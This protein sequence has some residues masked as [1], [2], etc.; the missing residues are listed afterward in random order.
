MEMI[1][2]GLLLAVPAGKGQVRH[3]AEQLLR[4]QRTF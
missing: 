1:P 4:T 2:W 3:L